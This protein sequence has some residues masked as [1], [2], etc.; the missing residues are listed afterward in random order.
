MKFILSASAK[1]YIIFQSLTSAT[2]LF[3]E[4]FTSSI[5]TV[6]DAPDESDRMETRIIGGNQASKGRYSYAVSLQDGIGHF[7]G[8]TLIATD[9]VLTAAHCQGGNYDVVVNRYDL[10]SNDGETISIDYEVPHPK[11][12]DKTTDNDFNLVFLSRPTKENVALMNINDDSNTPR[13]GS[14]VIVMGWG[15]TIS[16]D[17]TQ[18][19]ADKLLEVSVNAISNKDCDDSKGSIGGGSTSYK[20]LISDNMLCAQDS[21]EDACQGDSG[22]S[23]VVLSWVFHFDT[24]NSYILLFL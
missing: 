12:N 15:D 14:E 5:Q 24:V 3:A 23:S 4:T 17:Y 19:L 7:C 11:Y 2:S 1:L 18:K 21:G 16:D 6:E 22:K 9:V 13:V 8:G 10:N 20:N